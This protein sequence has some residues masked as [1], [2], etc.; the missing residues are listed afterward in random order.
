MER[1]YSN[2]KIYKLYVPG[3][4]QFCYIG[5]TTNS[6]TQRMCHHRHQAKNPAQ[7][8]TA[9]C[10]MFVD[11][12][13]PVIELVEAFP[14]NSKLELETRERYWIEQ[15]PDCI[16]TNKPTRTWKERWNENQERNKAEHKKWLKNNPEKVAQHREN[17]RE[18]QVASARAKRQAMTKEEREAH[19]KKRQEARAEKITC[20]ICNAEITKGQK[21]RHDKTHK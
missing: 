13:E 18:K 9:S 14:C 3:L 12:I 2:G 10:Q 1:D 11:D 17:A 5:S 16:N 7:N 20:A 19:N 4:E 6:L 8:K 15:T 21:Y